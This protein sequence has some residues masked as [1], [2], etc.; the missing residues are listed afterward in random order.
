MKCL[1]FNF[2]KG[3]IRVVEL[4]RESNAA[5]SV[6]K[7]ELVKI[8]PKL[9]FTELMDRY[10]RDFIE[11]IDHNK[12]NLLAARQVY[13]IDTIDGANF[14]IAPVAILGLLAKQ[15]QLSLNLYNAGGLRSAG[16]FGLEKGAKPIEAVDRLFGN[17]S[18]KAALL[19]AWRALRES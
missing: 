7:S 14:Q 12:P 6:V 5:I 9:E 8:D 10:K 13:D 19:V 15:K 3:K 16:P 18:P 11:L 2:Q 1:G 4:K 17:H